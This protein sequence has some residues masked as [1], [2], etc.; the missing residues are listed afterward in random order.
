MSLCALL[1]GAL[2]EMEDDEADG[3]EIDEDAGIGVL[4]P[5]KQ[6]APGRA[7]AKQLGEARDG[8]AQA[9]PS[10]RIQQQKQKQQQ[11][12]Q[13][14]QEAAEKPAKGGS[15]AGGRSAAAEPEEDGGGFEVVP[16][17]ADVNGDDVSDS[18]DDDSDAGMADLDENSRAE[19]RPFSLRS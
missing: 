19:V 2:D 14:K 8:T 18:D 13:K 1:S 17:R 12:Q 5:G 6:K 15:G 10:G 4:A 9:E 16:L 11:Q 3:L 7:A